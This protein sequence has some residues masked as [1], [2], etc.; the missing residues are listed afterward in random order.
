[1]TYSLLARDPLSGALGCA[2]AT[3]NLCVGA[4]VLRG[5]AGIGVSASQGHYPS[6][7]WGAAVLDALAE[8]TGLE[9]AVQ[10][11]VMA[12]QGRNARQLLALDQKGCGGSFSGSENLP[13]IED[14]I[15]TDIC[16][17]GNMLS[18]QGVITAAMDGY[19]SS[20]GSFVRKL[21]AGLQSGAGFGGDARGL[22]SAAILIVAEDHPPIDIRVDYAPDP[23]AALSDLADRIEGRDYLS[24]VNA[25]PTTAL[26]Y[27]IH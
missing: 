20:Q 25:L 24:W 9:H 4:W 11:T 26:P 8:G 17:G 22:M 18:R 27:P 19:L 2:S 12:D 7:I 14:R 23:L 10:S 16:A 3:G 1:M 21:L 5:R 6:T 13:V 15:D